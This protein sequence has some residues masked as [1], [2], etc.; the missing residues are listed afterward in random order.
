MVPKERGSRQLSAKSAHPAENGY[1]GLSEGEGGVKEE[2]YSISVTLL[3]A[4]VGTLTA[5]WSHSQFP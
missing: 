4:Q 5:T 3:P 1:P 2:W